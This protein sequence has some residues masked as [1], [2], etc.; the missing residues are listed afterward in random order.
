MVCSRIGSQ[1]LCMMR[2]I[3]DILP[4]FQEGSSLKKLTC[5]VEETPHESK[6]RAMAASSWTTA[7]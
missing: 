6:P 1:G 2:H 7:V 4:S 5:N 3:L